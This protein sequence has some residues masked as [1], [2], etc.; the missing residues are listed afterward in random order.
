MQIKNASKQIEKSELD[1]FNIRPVE[2]NTWDEWYWTRTRYEYGWLSG[3]DEIAL[4]F[5][6][7]AR[8][9][10]DFNR[11]AMAAAIAWW[12][13]FRIFNRSE[14]ANPI[15]VWFYSEKRC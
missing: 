12:G 8:L 7:Y 15:K 11:Y 5:D 4:E 3:L 6:Y 9:S 2:T 13:D 14:Y 1:N 10:I